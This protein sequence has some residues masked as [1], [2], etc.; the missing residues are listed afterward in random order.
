MALFFVLQFFVST[1]RGTSRT[2]GFFDDSLRRPTTAESAATSSHT[3]SGKL[4]M[5]PSVIRCTT[6]TG[7]PPSKPAMPAAQRLQAAVIALR[8]FSSLSA[9]RNS[10]RLS[11][12]T[13]SAFL[14]EACGGE[15]SSRGGSTQ[16]SDSNVC[17]SARKQGVLGHQQDRTAI[18]LQ[19]LQDGMAMPYSPSSLQTQKHTLAHSLA[20]TH[21][22]PQLRSHVSTES[23]SYPRSIARMQCCG[24]PWHAASAQFRPRP[25]VRSRQS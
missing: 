8:Q 16:T 2:K 11:T 13:P 9:G 19:R 1:E 6:S 5:T 18:L 3:S 7:G 21:A 17:A 15:R 10:P 4:E 25:S 14:E 24:T 12:S 22:A 20:R 23:C